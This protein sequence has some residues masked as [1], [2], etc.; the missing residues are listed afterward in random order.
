VERDVIDT[1]PV[2]WWAE[3]VPM[4]MR[5]WP[6]LRR[7]YWQAEEIAAIKREA[8]ELKRFFDQCGGD[9]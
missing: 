2:H 6:W 3:Y 5:T 4:F 8:A 9:E 7:F 1:E